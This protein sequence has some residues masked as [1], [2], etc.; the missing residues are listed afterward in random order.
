MLLRQS[1]S[2]AAEP[3][4]PAETQRA[5]TSGTTQDITTTIPPITVAHTSTSLS[6]GEP[7]TSEPTH[8]GQ[9]LAAEE[10]EHRS[11]IQTT[12][13]DLGELV[14]CFQTLNFEGRDEFFQRIITAIPPVTR[15]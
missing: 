5:T 1:G 4:F 6:S 15:T 7:Q 14:E 12:V 2:D 10:D 3:V 8:T 9:G 13:D 11:T